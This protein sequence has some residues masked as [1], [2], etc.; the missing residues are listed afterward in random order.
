METVHSNH[1]TGQ[2]SPARFYGIHLTSQEQEIVSQNNPDSTIQFFVLSLNDALK[3]L[4]RRGKI[5]SRRGSAAEAF[6]LLPKVKPR[7]GGNNHEQLRP[8]NRGRKRANPL[9]IDPSLFPSL[10]ER[11]YEQRMVQCVGREERLF[12]VRAIILMSASWWQVPTLKL[13]TRAEGRKSL[14]AAIKFVP[15]RLSTEKTFPSSFSFSLFSFSE[16][17]R[18]A[19]F[20]LFVLFFFSVRLVGGMKFE[21]VYWIGLPRGPVVSLAARGIIS[22]E[23]DVLNN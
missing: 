18:E 15:V 23:H 4:H 9:S 10:S 11:C 22:L 2:I 17:R 8:D 20:F 6:F 1:S 5:V 14:L 19:G 7:G 12:S 3:N 21:D 13:V 16:L